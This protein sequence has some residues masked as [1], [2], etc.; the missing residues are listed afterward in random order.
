MNKDKPETYEIVINLYRDL[1]SQNHKDLQKHWPI[2]SGYNVKIGV[3]SDYLIVFFNH[4]ANSGMKTIYGIGDLPSSLIG[5]NGIN[6]TNINSVRKKLAKHF[7]ATSKDAIFILKE[8]LSNIQTEL[9]EI[10]KQHESTLGLTPMKIFLSHK[11]I[12]KPK[13]REYKEVL[14]LLGFDIWLDEDAMSA[15]AELERELLQGFK[16]SCA[17]IFFVTPNYLDEQY[18]STEV[19]YAIQEKRAKGKEFSLIVLVME[20]NGKKGDVPELLKQY[21]WK[22][23]RND[24]EALNEMIKALPVQV[25]DVYWK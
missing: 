5:T 17:A 9:I 21:V 10:L 13:V 4:T 11:G 3:L 2:I 18:L 20:E 22:E 8:H 25:G 24:L 6:P 1:V 14:S 23:P 16:D 15:G 12:D 7:Q 19:N